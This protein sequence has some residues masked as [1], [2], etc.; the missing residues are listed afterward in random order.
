MFKLLKNEIGSLQL[1]KFFEKLHAVMILAIS[2][3]WQVVYV[4]MWFYFSFSNPYVVKFKKLR[5]KV[6]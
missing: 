4:V 5:F 2:L 6:V 1:K 3:V